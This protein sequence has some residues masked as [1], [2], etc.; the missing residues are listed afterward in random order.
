MATRTYKDEFKQ[1]V[2]EFTRIIDIAMLKEVLL[3]I[4]K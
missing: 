2:V 1:W 3:T 4:K